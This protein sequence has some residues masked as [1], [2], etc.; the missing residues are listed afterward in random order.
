MNIAI[1]HYHLHPGGVTRVIHAQ[2]EAL[3]GHSLRLY[4][5]ACDEGDADKFDADMRILPALDYLPEDGYTSEDFASRESHIYAA[6]RTAVDEGYILHIHNPGLGKNPAL[7]AAFRRLVCEGAPVVS[8]CHDFPEDRPE[9]DAY[10]S[11][12]AQD[13]G[14]SLSDLLYPDGP[15]VHYL[16]LTTTDCERLRAYGVPATHI[17]RA[18]NPIQAPD[19]DISR[20]DAHAQICRSCDI[21]ASCRIITYPI[22]VIQR[23]NVP[24]ILL[25]AALFQNDIYW[26][27]TLPPRN[28]QEK[29]AY[30]HWKSCAESHNLPVRFDVGLTVPFP[31]IMRGSSAIISTSIREGFGMAFL[32]PWMY[33]VPVIGR[34]LPSVTDDFINEG[35]RFTHLY[36]TIN[37]EHNGKTVDFPALPQDAAT[38][39]IV[40]A[41]KDSDVRQDILARNSTLTHMMSPVEE[42]IIAHNRSCITTTYSLESYGRTL[43]KTY[44]AVA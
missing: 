43:R 40:R 32:E 12:V 41:A 5:G 33:D 37:V 22:R 29:P 30:E 2:L 7:T 24:E 15:H 25:L 11:R 18:P 21:P 42:D 9:N 13:L 6:L 4:T 26:L 39:Y 38:D 3:K 16:A 34:N 10:L 31:T 23:K 19:D 28:P 27:V 35:M 8:H 44:S 17:T 36:D 14:Y 1:V 20:Q